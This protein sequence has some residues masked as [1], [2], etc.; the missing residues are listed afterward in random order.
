LHTY[1]FVSCKYLMKPKLPAEIEILF[2]VD[3]VRIIYSFVPHLPRT[4]HHSPSMQ[5]ELTRIQN[6]NLAGKKE[7]YMRDLEEFLL[8]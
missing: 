2:P 1:N 7:T 3:V 5:K 8:S 6:M 4:P